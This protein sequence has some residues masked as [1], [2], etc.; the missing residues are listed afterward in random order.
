MCVCVRVRVFMYLKR[1]SSSVSDC[2]IL[3]IA[4]GNCRPQR[5]FSYRKLL[6]KGSCHRDAHICSLLKFSAI[7]TS[8][9]HAKFTE[10]HPSL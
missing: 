6:N 3:M 2:C 4:T 1:Q 9:T 7:I 10:Q 8:Q 5:S